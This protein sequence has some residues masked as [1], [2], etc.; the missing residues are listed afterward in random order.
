M[1]TRWAR[2]CEPIEGTGTLCISPDRHARRV[3]TL[4][5]ELGPLVVLLPEGTLYV[6]ATPDD[7][8]EIITTSIE[9]D[10]IVER[11]TYKAPETK[12]RIS[13]ELDIPFYA[14][15]HRIVFGK[16]GKIDP[17]SIDDYIAVG[18]YAS[19]AKA[20]TTM[21]PE[22]IIDGIEKSGLRGRGGGGFPTGRKW[23]ACREAEGYPKYVLCNGDEGDPGAFMDR[24]IMEGN[25]HS[26]LEGM[27]IG[28]Y[29]IGS[30]HGYIY[31][32]HEYPLL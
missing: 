3:R 16:S 11:L 2:A 12:K 23:R 14:N 9:G 28:A 29:A 24:S 25:P 21:Q 32:R 26:V 27:A 7:V 20:I 17:N 4:F 8:E 31:V 1:L 10:G 22:E 18:G 15:Q 5:C 30:N 6:S 13:R 19:L